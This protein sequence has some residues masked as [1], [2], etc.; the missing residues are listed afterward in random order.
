MTTRNMTTLSLITATIIGFNGCGS[1]SSSKAP[2]SEPVS[3]ITK[4]SEASQKHS[5]TDWEVLTGQINALD[6]PEKFNTMLEG[7]IEKNVATLIGVGLD[8]EEA[9]AINSDM[10][11]DDLIDLDIEQLDTAIVTEC[12]ENEVCK[13]EAYASLE[14]DFSGIDKEEAYAIAQDVRDNDKEEAYAIVVNDGLVK[15]FRCASDEVKTVRHYGFEDIFSTANGVE[16][17]SQYPSDIDQNMIDYNN[18]VN[19]GF[20]NYDETSVNRFFLDNIDNLPA[21]VISGRFYIGLK[22]NG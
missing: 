20:A 5:D 6:K 16:A 10:M 9:Y 7:S 15:E 18:H 17:T 21:N 22:S 1:S 14:V 13:E 4:L 19:A 11:Y 8:K 3:S 12:Q 2:T